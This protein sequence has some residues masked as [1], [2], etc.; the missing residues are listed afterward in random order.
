MIRALYNHPSIVTWIPIIEGW[1]QFSTKQ[2]TDMIHKLDSSRL[3]DSASG[4]FDQGCGDIN[5][6]HYYFL[7]LPIP[8]S[9]RVLALSEFGGYSLRIPEHSACNNN[10]GYKKFTTSDGLTSGF[11]HLMED[12]I[13]PS[14]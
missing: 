1:G 9:K 14:V 12:T 10:Y 5:S 3:V 11:A 7:G 6:L 8:R 2:V 4:W 13:V